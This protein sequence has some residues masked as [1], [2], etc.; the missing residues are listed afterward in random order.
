[1]KKKQKIPSPFMNEPRYAMKAPNKNDLYYDAMDAMNDGNSKVAVSLL[2]QALKLD[3]DY[4]QTHHGLSAVYRDISNIEKYR[5]HTL[6]AYDE[7]RKIFQKWP[8]ELPWGDMDNRQYHRA[9]F[10]RADL[11]IEDGEEDKAI[12]L[13]RLL[14]SMN[15]NDNLGVRYY[16]AAIYDGYS[17]DEIGKMWSDANERQ[18]WNAMEKLVA[19]QNKKH[20][21][22][23]EPRE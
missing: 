15:P 16:L 9:I 1:M 10:F 7:T 13:Y 3:P 19:I 4:I 11:H 20:K 23:K 6:K 2:I 8:K 22:W 21:F 12:E 14:L 17:L 5:L 18:N